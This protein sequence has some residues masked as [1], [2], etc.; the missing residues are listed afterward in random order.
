VA[1][2][3][4]DRSRRRI[5]SGSRLPLEKQAAAILAQSIGECAPDEHWNG[6]YVVARV[7]VSLAYVV[8]AAGPVETD[9]SGDSS[10]GIFDFQ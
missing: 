7:R 2:N 5:A 4:D 8:V 1:P 10:C 6:A 9:L 3:R